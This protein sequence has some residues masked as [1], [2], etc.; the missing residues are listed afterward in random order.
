MQEALEQSRG[1]EMPKIEF[2]EDL[3]EITEQYQIFVFDFKEN[4]QK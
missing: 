4:Q 2:V 1:W 3:K